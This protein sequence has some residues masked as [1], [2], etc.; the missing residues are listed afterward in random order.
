MPLSRRYNPE[1][2]P[3]DACTF[4][5]DFSYLI[6]P[7]VGIVDAGIAIFIN[8]VDPTPIDDFDIGP[9]S[10]RGRAVYA[11]LTGGVD[12]TDYQLAWTVKDS[13]GNI[14]TRTALILCADTS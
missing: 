5:M 12:G 7:G 10:W 9:V 8:S 14:F 2:A 1:H 11:L 3:G 6:P 4:G 13:Q